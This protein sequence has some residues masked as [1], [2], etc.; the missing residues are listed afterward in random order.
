MSET[1]PRSA[2]LANVSAKRSSGDAQSA[3]APSADAGVRD[4][5]RELVAHDVVEDRVVDDVAELVQRHRVAVD[6]S[7]AVQ[8]RDVEPHLVGLVPNGRA[9]P[10]TQSSG[11][12]KVETVTSP[13]TSSIKRAASG[14]ALATAAR[15]H[16]RSAAATPDVKVSRGSV[17]QP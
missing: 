11:A 13:S 3:R 14:R 12:L 5:D 9:M 8:S 6:L 1:A 10:R 4:L 2:H 17:R 7:G 16:S 15:I